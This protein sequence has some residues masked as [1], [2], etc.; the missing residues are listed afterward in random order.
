MQRRCCDMKKD[1]EKQL[2]RD[3][4]LAFGKKEIIRKDE[5]TIDFDEENMQTYIKLG[6]I[7]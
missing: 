6:I 5:K 3:L 4:R 7:R 1:Y 2:I